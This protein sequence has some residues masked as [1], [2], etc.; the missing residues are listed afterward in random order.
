MEPNLFKYDLLVICM[1]RKSY[2][3]QLAGGFV[4]SVLLNV[5]LF[6]LRWKLHFFWILQSLMTKNKCLIWK[7]KERTISNF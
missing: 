3:Q 1:I 4:H 7:N 2:M 5:F 6:I